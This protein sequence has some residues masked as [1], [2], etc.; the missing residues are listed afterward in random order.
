MPTTS[1]SALRPGLLSRFYAALYDL[2]IAAGERRGMAAMRRELLTAATGRVLEI[3]A[4]TGRNITGYPPDLTGLVLTEPDRGMLGRLRTRLRRTDHA[5]TVLPAAA[6][7]LPFP[8]A[9]FDT[10]ISTLVLCTVPDPAAAI[11]EVLRVLRP[12]GRLLFI[13][14][15][16]ADDARLA[17]RQDRWH[18]PWRAFAAGCHCNRP[19]LALLAKHFPTEPTHRTAGWH[20]MPSIVRP[21]VIGPAVQP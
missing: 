2:F 11:D 21:L 14:H 16:R 12:G 9:T 19:T 5:V 10:V 17:R 20:A 15:V 3:G 4:G 13:E 18:R 8:S 1:P 6:E 7:S